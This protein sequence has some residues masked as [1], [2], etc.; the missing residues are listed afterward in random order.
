MI[1]QVPVVAPEI[2]P[3]ALKVTEPRVV[4]A[5]ANVNVLPLTIAEVNIVVV[6][7][8]LGLEAEVLVLPPP[9]QPYIII[10]EHT[11]R[12]TRILFILSPFCE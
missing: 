9:P 7:P 8:E 10:I 6:V 4:P 5:T 11:A 1:V 2:V 3:S 12:P